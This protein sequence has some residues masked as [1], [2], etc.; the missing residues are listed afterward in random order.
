MPSRPA[1]KVSGSVANAESAPCWVVLAKNDRYA[2]VSNTASDSVS[3]YRV[4][5]DGAVSLIG[6]DGRAADTG[7]GSKPIDMALTR[8]D[9]HLYVLDSGTA[10]LSGFSVANDGT[11]TP[12]GTTNGLPATA[13]GLAAY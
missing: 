11:L 6:A 4:A 3:A 12:A 5:L 13:V 2:Y 8:N 7:E 1:W 10:Q 9:R